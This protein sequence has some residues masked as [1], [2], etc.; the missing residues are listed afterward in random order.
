MTHQTIVVGAGIGGLMAA[1]ELALAGAQVTV[2]EAQDV[3]GGKMRREEVGRWSM[4]VGPT[5]LTLRHVFDELFDRAGLQLADAVTLHKQTH[6]ARH[7]WPDGTLLD[8]YPDVERSAD[9]VAEAF[10][11]QAA[12]GYRS[13]VAYAEKLYAS[14]QEAF[15]YAPRPSMVQAMWHFGRRAFTAA[16]EMDAGRTMN[17]ALHDFFPKHQPM[18]QLFGRYATYT[19]ASPYLAPATLHLISHVE[20]L[21]VW[22]VVGGLS[23]LA[24]A[25]A[26]LIVTLGGTVR[27]NAPVA[28]VVTRLGRARGVRLVDGSF[29]SADAVVL[30]ADI[31]AIEAKTLWPTKE[32]HLAGDPSAEGLSAVVYGMVG[33]TSGLELKGH[34][35]L[36][37]ANGGR[38]EFDALF[39]DRT[40][41]ADPSVY[42]YA[43]DRA[44]NPDGEVNGQERLF[45][46]INAPAGMGPMTEE[47]AAQWQ[48]TLM[49][50]LGQAGMNLKL[51]QAPL[52]RQPSDFA[53]RFWGSNGA[54]YGRPPHGWRGFF[55]RPGS[56]T[57]THGLYV[58][59][60][61]VHPGAGVPMAALSGRLAA[62]AVLKD[63]PSRPQSPMGV[64]PGGTWTPPPTTA[65]MP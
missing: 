24:H 61:G 22:S 8:L 55:T 9:A 64:T 38:G 7:V 21:G 62:Q 31:R 42:L 32:T 59:G 11:A 10:G 45:A 53:R 40:M 33:Q 57:S 41:V 52:M 18:R 4:D 20:R 3:P 27:Y 6:L 54:L 28:E 15:I 47:R 46:L 1:A 26:A 35:V 16:K 39:G 36:F 51:Q 17:A 56:R 49:Q 50:R 13:Y 14:A 63:A 58:A 44:E 19:G 37:R 25:M 60:G 48:T 23:R 65:T 12:R 5:V 2:L 43:L 30:N 29:V 34:N